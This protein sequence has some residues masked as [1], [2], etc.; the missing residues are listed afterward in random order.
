VTSTTVYYDKELI[1]TVKV[2]L[3]RPNVIKLFLS[4]IYEFLDKARAFVKLG[5]ESLAGKTV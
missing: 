4:V 1:T 3:Y 5:W 2:S